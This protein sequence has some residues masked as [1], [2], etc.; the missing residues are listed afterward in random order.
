MIGAAILGGTGYGAGELLRLL[1]DHPEVEV[2]S[3]VSRSLPGERVDRAHSHLAGFYDLR[4]SEEVDWRKMAT[5]R[6]S[7]LFSA[8]PNGVSAKAIADVAPACLELGAK[9]VDMSGDFRLKDETLSARFYPSTPA[10][11]SLRSQFAY[12]LTETNRAAIAEAQFVANPGCLATAAIL[13]L[14]PVASDAREPVFDLKTGSSGSG[15]EP[16]DTTVHAHRSANVYAYKALIHQHEPETLQALG[17]ADADCSF[18][19]HSLPLV[20]G[21]VATTHFLCAAPVTEAYR[22]WCADNPFLRFRA[23]SPE[24]QDVV[25]TNF[26]DLSVHQRG[27]RCVA[28]ACIDNLG[29]GMAGQAIQNMNLMCGLPE[30]TGLWRPA[31]R[32][33]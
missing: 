27:S 18:I 1:L 6:Q 24:V 16:K 7:V 23:G 19:A 33:I 8:L 17:L 13:S 2:A 21:I 14:A 29:K 10:L 20:R 11:P 3:V 25:A 28:I 12:G 32:P 26:C 30:T 22:S 5:Y 15:R 9:V 4:F 31:P